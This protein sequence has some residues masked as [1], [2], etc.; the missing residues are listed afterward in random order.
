[1]CLSDSARDN[2][3]L[4]AG[5]TDCEWTEQMIYTAERRLTARISYKLDGPIIYTVAIIVDHMITAS[6]S[7]QP[8]RRSIYVLSAPRNKLEQSQLLTRLTY[9]IHAIRYI[10]SIA[11]ALFS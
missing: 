3:R 2:R 11:V 7:V 4:L 8:K 9:E 1:M 6:L 10:L 5:H